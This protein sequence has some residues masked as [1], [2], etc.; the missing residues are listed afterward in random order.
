M[1][2]LNIENIDEDNIHL[3]NSD[4]ISLAE[5]VHN[6]LEN[7]L[8]NLFEISDSNENMKSLDQNATV[9]F[10]NLSFWRKFLILMNKKFIL[11]NTSII[12]LSFGLSFQSN[13]L[14]LF[15]KDY[16]HASGFL[17]GF[18]MLMSVLWELPFFFFGD[19][20]LGFLGTKL[21]MVTSILSF[22]VRVLGYVIV[23][24]GWWVIPFESL[25]GIIFSCL[26]IASVK[27]VSDIS[28]PGL[29][30]TAQGIMNSGFIGV[31][32][33]IGSL[34]GGFIYRS[35]GPYFLYLLAAGSNILNLVLFYTTHSI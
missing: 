3:S 10:K 15:L 4:D 28:P 32:F 34:I 27:Y 24:N 9:N 25:H 20:L 14:F 33:G 2:I 5:L 23:P 35:Y 1:E 17:L 26:W 13:F 31:G 6:D 18:L 8:M 19:K 21:M 22:I 16:L 7:D 30:S 11:Y 29:E 12:I